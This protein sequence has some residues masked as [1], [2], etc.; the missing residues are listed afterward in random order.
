LKNRS[1]T[2]DITQNR[3]NRERLGAAK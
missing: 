2:D 3:Y 1:W